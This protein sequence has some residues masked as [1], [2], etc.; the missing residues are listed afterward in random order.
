[1]ME[2]TSQ[3]WRRTKVIRIS[4]IR[5]FI[6]VLVLPIV[7][8]AQNPKVDLA[9]DLNN[10]T[11]EP[12]LNT[13]SAVLV[14]IPV[15]DEWYIGNELIP[16]NQLGRKINEL[17]TGRRAADRIVYIAGGQR[18]DYVNVV[19]VVQMIREQD[20][21][22][23]GLIVNG[24]DVER[25]LLATFLITVPALRYADKDV[26][27][28]KPNPLTLM[29]TVSSK[30]DLKLNADSGPRRGELCYSSVPNGLGSDPNNL[31]KWLKCLFDNRTRQH[32]YKVG[33]E[34]RTEVPLEQR[35]EKTVFVN[36]SRSIKYGDVLRVVNALKGAGT[37]PIGLKIDDLPD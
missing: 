4:A 36:A 37:N 30:L 7:A 34:T 11:A 3:C 14:S 9:S 1:V 19:E 23:F 12:A 31:Q 29:V 20:V 32:A 13:E 25:A 21:D 18:V 28:L 24:R 15:N 22:Q 16:K 2:R 26:A 27:N 33:M 17:L 5:F 35:I 6:V 10:A 8:S